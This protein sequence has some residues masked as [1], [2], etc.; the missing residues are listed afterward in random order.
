MPEPESQSQKPVSLSPSDVVQVKFFHLP[1]PNCEC[2]E[3]VEVVRLL[4]TRESQVI[5]SAHCSSC[6]TASAAELA[7]Q[8]FHTE[9]GEH[10]M[11]NGAFVPP[12]REGTND[13]GREPADAAAE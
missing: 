5:V 12:P 3:P 8:G 13:A 4:V 11:F 1:E 7:Q 6:A 10:S 9:R 2:G